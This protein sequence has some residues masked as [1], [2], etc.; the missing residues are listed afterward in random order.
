MRLGIT[1]VGDSLQHFIRYVQQA[2][3]AG[4]AAIGTGD[5][6]TLYGELWVRCT[7]AGTHAARARVGPWATNPITRHPSVTAGAAATLAELTAG[8]AYLGIATGDAAVYNIGRQP[9]TLAYLESYIHTVRDLLDRGVATWEGRTVHLDYA[10]PPVP[11]AMPAS[12]PRALRLAGRIAD[13]VWVCTGLQP[14]VI[15]AAQAH[16][17]QGAAEAGRRLED[18]DIWWVALVNVGPPRQEAIRQLQFSL[19]SYAHIIFRYT[20]EG[21]A[22]PAA[23]AEPIRRLVSGYQSRAHIKPGEANPNAQL[24]EELGLTTYLADR[25]TIAGTVE[26]CLDQLQRLNAL[27]IRQ[28]WTPIRFADKGPLMQVLCEELMPR[29]ATAI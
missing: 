15:A 20:L 19:A 22:V 24:V 4:V 5:S 17:A 7:L 2:D 13:M 11:I 10:H 18:L 25:L 1:I 26:E 12:G 9:A 16:L 21:K 14:E 27:G 3:R 28:I 6:Q 29:L 8:R 23:F